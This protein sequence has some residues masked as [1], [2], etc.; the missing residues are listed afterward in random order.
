[1]KH[2]SLLFLIVTQSFGSI[3]F[4]QLNLFPQPKKIEPTEPAAMFELPYSPASNAALTIEGD[5]EFLAALPYHLELLHVHQA[6]QNALFTSNEIAVGRFRLLRDVQVQHEEGYMLDVTSEGITIRASG[7]A[8]AMYAIA[9]LAQWTDSTD[10]F[11]LKWPHVHIEDQPAF[12]HR[13]FMLDVSRHFFDVP[14]I[15]RYLDLMGMHKMNVFHWHLTDDQ[16][17]RLHLKRFP[18][19]TSIGAQRR[20]SIGVYGGFYT[21]EDVATVLD[22]AQLLNITVIPE[23]EMPGH[24]VAA[25]AAYPQ[26]SCTGEKLEVATDWGVFKDVY[27]VS[28]PATVQFLHDVLDEVCRIFP[29]PLVHIGGDEVPTYRWE[30]CDQCQRKMEEQDWDMHQFTAA[31]FKDIAAHLDAHGKA[32]IGW[33]EIADTQVPRSAIVQCWRG[34]Q[35]ASIAARAGRRAIVSPTSHCY[36]DYP[37][38]SID[39]WKVARFDPTP[40]SLTSAEAAFIVGGEVNLWSEHVPNVAKLDAQV[41]PRLSA[42]SEVM[43]SDEA[44]RESS[45]DEQLQARLLHQMQRLKVRQVQQGF[46][47]A[48][49]QWNV[50]EGDAQHLVV[51]AVPTWREEGLNV[52]IASEQNAVTQHGQA[53]RITVN[54]ATT[55]TA[56]AR[57]PLV[58]QPQTA[59]LKVAPH[60]AFRKPLVLSYTPSKYYTGGGNDALVDG[61]LGS[62]DFRDGHW[63]AVQ[64]QNMEVVIDLQAETTISSVQLQWYHYQQAWIFRPKQLK[65]LVSNDGKKWK[66]VATQSLGAAGANDAQSIEGTT[67]HFK[68]KTTRYIKVLAEN[69]GPCPAWHA[70][71]GEPSW[72]FLDEVMVK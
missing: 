43:W 2:L 40:D 55:L 32:M 34:M 59:T 60:A 22:H 8:G 23:I 17:W 35:Q 25:L 37:L 30:H 52:E 61:I 36:L 19:L 44:W 67:L 63:Q 13:G 42:F 72:L 14:T 66:S 49:V 65:V 11:S 70:A 24:A 28:N 31:F 64:G 16:G 48:A 53:Q 6:F 58:Q 38:A 47:S 57:S 56:Q 21:E 29:G 18:E 5:P 20:D 62:Y 4:G 50:V 33:D 15:L 68:K 1:M 3:V 27:C 71:A 69:S 7:N 51:E 45:T 26:Y 54:A 10:A 12:P 46:P 9:T 39:A 41:F